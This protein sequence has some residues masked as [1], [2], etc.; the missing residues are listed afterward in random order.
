VQL[1]SFVLG[2]LQKKIIQIFVTTGISP[3]NLKSIGQELSELVPYR[4]L[5]LQLFSH[6][7]FCQEKKQKC[8]ACSHASFSKI[9]GKSSKKL[10]RYLI[11]NQAPG[12]P[13]AMR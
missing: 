11:L 2:V 3:E 5:R 13:L 7:V 10:P 12:H 6:I 8:L 1:T 4:T 9:W